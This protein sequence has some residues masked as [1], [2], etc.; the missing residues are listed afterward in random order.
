MSTTTAH[1]TLA[2][3]ASRGRNILV[4]YWWVIALRGAFGIIFGMIALLVPVAAIVG[5]V[6]LFA[7][8]MLL[9]GVFAFYT[10]Y[11]AG[12]RGKPWGIL[13]LQGLADIVAGLISALWPG[14]TV[15]AFVLLLAAWALV[16]GCLQIA[17][18]SHVT[19]GRWWLLLGGLASLIYGVLLVVA[20]MVGA[21][22]LTWWMGA[23]AI[24][25]G[26]FLIVAAFRLGLHREKA[27]STRPA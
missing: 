22:V 23:W 21:L 13:L 16:S 24:V 14:I 25:F 12:R 9:D 6:L 1:E 2:D 19:S 18:A 4:Q 8:Y 20:P 17:A 10:A 27:P 11:Q 3:T 26:A 15:L 7:A 5:L